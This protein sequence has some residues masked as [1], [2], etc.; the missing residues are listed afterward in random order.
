M[1]YEEFINNEVLKVEQEKP[2]PKY[3]IIIEAMKVFLLFAGA[4][5]IVSYAAY[6]NGGYDAA[7][8]TLPLYVQP[9]IA[10]LVR[11]RWNQVVL[12]VVLSVIFAAWLLLSPALVV[13]LL[14]G[15]YMLGV[16]AYQV[17]REFS[18]SE[19]REAGILIICL[20]AVL[21]VAV[22][23]FAIVQ[24]MR[25]FEWW[26]GGLVL[27]YAVLFARYQHYIAIADAIKHLESAA[28]HSHFS[29]KRVRRINNRIVWS[30]IALMLA[31]IGLAYA[32]GLND[33]VEKAAAGV[34]AQ[35][36]IG[37]KK[38]YSV[39]AS[40]T[41]T[42]MSDK[43]KDDRAK[44][45]GST[46]E[47]SVW[48][49]NIIRGIIIGWCVIAVTALII[50]LIREDRMRRRS[51]GNWEDLGY[52]ETHEFYRGTAPKRS[53]RRLSQIMDRSPENLVRRAYYKRV[54][55]EMGKAVKR[56]DTPKQVGAK[57]SGLEPLVRQYNEV[58]YKNEK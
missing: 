7:L 45:D 22:G 40:G 13:T 44:W 14:G 19:E 31:S 33:A 41:S 37:N 4:A 15:V 26:L 27:V 18:E 48:M 49:G 3:P 43:I 8:Y 10:T 1:T 9:W 6:Y 20:N 28:Q 36:D 39:G 54:K 57:L 35:I 29:T 25:G 32:T 55:A 12:D 58:R 34:I 11:R 38:Y 51:D 46:Q 42:E 5:G 17:V 16:T 47:E 53:R 24:G 56:S 50:Y 52:E 23:I 21:M 30:F 2:L